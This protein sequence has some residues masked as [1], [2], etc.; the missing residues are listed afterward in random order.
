MFVTCKKSKKKFRYFLKKYYFSFF[1]INKNICNL[2]FQIS[3][4]IKHMILNSHLAAFFFFHFLDTSKV[5][6]KT[7]NYFPK[8]PAALF[9]DLSFSLRSSKSQVS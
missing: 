2:V 4:S 3:L 1:F 8:V 9:S 5:D 6:V 7:W